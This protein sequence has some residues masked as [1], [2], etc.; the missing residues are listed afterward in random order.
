[1]DPRDVEDTKQTVT[2]NTKDKVEKIYQTKKDI[3]HAKEVVHV[4]KKEVNG[5]AIKK[6]GAP[7]NI[8]F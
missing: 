8:G 6:K 7:Q 2:Y 4:I 1:M 5:T 3:T